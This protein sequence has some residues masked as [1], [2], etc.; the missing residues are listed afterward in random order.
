MIFKEACYVGHAPLMAAVASVC[1]FR[2]PLLRLPAASLKKVE[3]AARRK[4]ELPCAPFREDVANFEA[5]PLLAPLS[6]ASFVRRVVSEAYFKLAAGSSVTIE[7]EW[8]GEPVATRTQVKSAAASWAL[9]GAEIDL[10]ECL[11]A[12]DEDMLTVASPAA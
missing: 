8:Q 9:S 11:L 1:C 7:I 12:W 6:D 10:E 4:P 2:S 3:M 5:A